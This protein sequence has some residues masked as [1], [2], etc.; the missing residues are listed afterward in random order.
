M[1][2]SVK[3]QPSVT[4]EAKQADELDII[5]FVRDMMQRRNRLPCQLAADLGVSHPTVGR[6]LSGK[7]VPSPS[8][9]RKLAEYSGLPLEK[10]LAMAG[11]LPGLNHT[12]PA[13]WP[14]FREYVNRKYPN[15]LD[16]DVISIIEDLIERR[17]I[18]KYRQ[19]FEPE[20]TAG[21]QSGF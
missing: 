14:E 2:L 20:L 10:I 18:R 15:E 6:W 8:S 17:R 1:T 12:A 13:D 5:S 21:R 11:H 9:C 19:Q 4:L 7:D 16:E 3:L